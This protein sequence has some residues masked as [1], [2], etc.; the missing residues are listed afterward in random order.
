MWRYRM[1]MHAFISDDK[2]NL[3]AS[4]DFGQTSKIRVWIKVNSVSQLKKQ[5]IYYM[6][7]CNKMQEKFFWAWIECTQQK[8]N[9]NKM[10]MDKWRHDHLIHIIIVGNYIN[11]ATDVKITDCNNCQSLLWNHRHYQFKCGILLQ[12]YLSFNFLV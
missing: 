2:E 8:F 6:E 11:S 4:D 7:L 9:K 3:H 12:L 1:Q 5:H 10:Q